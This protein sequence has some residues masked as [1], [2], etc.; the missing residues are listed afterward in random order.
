MKVSGFRALLRTG[1]GRETSCSSLA[2]TG[3]MLGPGSLR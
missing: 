1:G 2:P 3:G